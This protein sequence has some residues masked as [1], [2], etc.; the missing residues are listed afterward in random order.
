MS[1]QNS[2]DSLFQ[3]VGN[4]SLKWELLIILAVGVSAGL[5]VLELIGNQLFVVAASVLALFYVLKGKSVHESEDLTIVQKIAHKLMS[6]AQAVCI[7][8]ILY[9]VSSWPGDGSMLIAGMIGTSIGTLLGAYQ[10]MNNKDLQSPS[11]L[12]LLRVLFWMMSAVLVWL[13]V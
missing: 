11:N 9:R 12:D 3:K 13:F 7:V 2:I 5:S 4:I 6:Y 10:K 1:Q 8:G